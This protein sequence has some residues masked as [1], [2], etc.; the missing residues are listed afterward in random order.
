MM[1]NK[2][3]LDNGI[4]ALLQE[5]KETSGGALQARDIQGI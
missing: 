2:T 3:N 4:H 5:E 1:L